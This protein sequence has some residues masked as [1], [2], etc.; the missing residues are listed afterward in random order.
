MECFIRTTSPY[1]YSEVIEPLQLETSSLYNSKVHL[2]YMIKVERQYRIVHLKQQFFAR[3]NMLIYTYNVKGELVAEY[4]YIQDNCYYSGY[5]EGVPDSQVVLSTC[6][7]LWG[8]IQLEALT[9]EIQPVENSSTFQHLISRSNWEAR[10][11]CVGISEDGASGPG[12]EM[13]TVRTDEDANLSTRQQGDQNQMGH[14][15]LEYYAVVDK[16]VFLLY[17]SNETVLVSVIFH[18]MLHVHTIFLPLGLHVYLVGMEIWRDKNYVTLH[19]HDLPANLNAFNKYV[20]YNL[21]HREHFDH[22]GLMTATGNLPGFSWREWLC[23]PSHVSVS[24]IQIRKNPRFDA[25]AI[26]HQLGHSLD[27]THDDA[28]ANSEK[29]CDCNCTVFGSCLMLT[30]GPANC[31]R[32]SNCSTL[33]YLKLIQKPEKS[34]LL[35]KPAQVFS[36]KEC[37]NGVIDDEEE[38]CDC[39]VEEDIEGTWIQRIF[40]KQ[41]GK[42]RQLH[43]E[44]TSA[45]RIVLMNEEYP[46]LKGP[47]ECRK[48]GCCQK[49]CQFKKDIDCLYGLCCEKCQFSQAGTQCREAASE[50]DLP[51]FCNGTSYDCPTDVYKQDGTPCGHHDHCFLGLCLDLHTHCRALFGPDAREAPLSCFKTM[52]MPGDRFGNCG[53][54]GS[55]FRPCP[56]KDVLCGRVQC[57][58]GKI[59][60]IANG[61]EVLQTPVDGTLCWGTEFDLGEDIY[62]LGAVRD[63]T[64]CGPDKICLNRSCV[65][66]AVLDF[67]C[68]PAVCRHRGVCNSNRNCHCSY[69]WAPPLCSDPGYGGSIDSGPPPPYQ[70]P[71]IVIV[72]LFTLIGLVVLAAG[73]YISRHVDAIIK[74]IAAI[75][76]RRP[77]KS[78]SKRALRGRSSKTGVKRSRSDMRSSSSRRLKKSQIAIALENQ[79]SLPYVKSPELKSAMSTSRA[80]KS[81][82]DVT[83]AT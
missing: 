50:C 26:A 80:G 76:K 65:D 61:Q 62:D 75:P 23:H 72:G 1:L 53:K 2:S 58:N 45:I 18:M 78:A 8:H 63:G 10:E 56:E 7:G 46:K 69:G 21:R 37:G 52:N 79:R 54:D 6:N 77:Q 70:L 82:L 5:V 27:F 55:Y 34:C 13:R 43:E 28:Q 41:G 48:N 17:G 42:Q 81:R 14:R 25:E 39:G 68:D 36:T 51:E 35:D 4:P 73:V 32:L 30:S 11:P 49:D 38:Q 44:G 31:S 64:S 12:R 19:P 66:V 29:K 33:E 71:T 22:A 60:S 40:L 3:E 24:I 9:Y 74:W 16:S 67:D 47:A 83:F 59:S 15:Y 57:V 20:R